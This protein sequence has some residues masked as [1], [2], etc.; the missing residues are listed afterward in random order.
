MKNN[1]SDLINGT[2]Y[3]CVFFFGVCVR[4]CVCECVCACDV[5]EL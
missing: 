2:Y 1:S 4:V 5:L 3:A